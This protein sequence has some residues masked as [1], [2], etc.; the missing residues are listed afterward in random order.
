MVSRYGLGGL[1]R[2][3]AVVVSERNR[4]KPRFA[5]IMKKTE[6][7]KYVFLARIVKSKAVQEA[8]SASMSNI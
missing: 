1:L 6:S 5:A 2:R 3:S 7:R 8:L 4:I